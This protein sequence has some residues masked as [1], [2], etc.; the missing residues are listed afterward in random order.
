MIEQTAELIWQWLRT[1]GAQAAVI[2]AGA[3]LLYRALRVGLTR[4]ERAVMADG[5]TNVD[6]QRRVVTLV[7]VARSTGLVAIV[8][9]ASLMLL[10]KLG[11]NITPLIAGAGVIGL[12]IGLGAQTLIRDLI[13]GLFIVFEDQYHVGDAVKVG[14]VSGSVERITLRVTYLR[15][16]D[17]TLHIV[18]NGEMRVVS[19]RTTGWSRA[20]VDVSVGYAQD[21]SRALAVLREVASEA[22]ADPALKPLLIEPLAVT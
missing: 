5:G 11:F 2:L 13:G 19:N 21:I 8:V 9:A 3:W 14:G 4:L 20:V 10:A 16:L 7:G 12:A 6:R 17:G 18:P 1:T 22:N 15:D